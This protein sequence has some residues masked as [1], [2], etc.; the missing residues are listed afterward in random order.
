MLLHNPQPSFVHCEYGN[1]GKASQQQPEPLWIPHIQLP[2]TVAHPFFDRLNE[3][4]EKHE[5]DEFVEERCASFY[6]ERVGAAIGGAGAVFPHV[7]ERVFRRDRQR[8]RGCLA[9]G[10]F[11]LLEETVDERH[12]AD[13]MSDGTKTES[14]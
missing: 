14:P 10:G 2:Q 3:V 6:A 12:S 9:R 11:A 4:L 5:F 13:V 1:G 8:A 7:T